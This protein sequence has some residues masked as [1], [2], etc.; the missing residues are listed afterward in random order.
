MTSTNSPPIRLIDFKDFKSLKKMPR[1]PEEKDICVKIDAI[2][3]DNSLIIYISHVWLRGKEEDEGFK[4][5]PHP[6]NTDHDHFELC[7]A[8]IK[9]LKK[10]FAPDMKKCYLWLDFG[11]LNQDKDPFTA[12]GAQ[13]ETI[14]GLSDCLFTPLIGK[15]K[16]SKNGQKSKSPIT[17]YYEQFNLRSWNGDEGYLNHAWCRT[18]ILLC[19]SSSQLS[20]GDSSRVDKFRLQFRELTLT[21]SRPHV[22]FSTRELEDESDPMM[23][24]LQGRW[25]SIYS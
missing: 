19:S 8:G 12:H 21:G 11:C 18:E 7:V 16:T 6:D 4:K 20:V 13:L 9:A 2:D 24:K 22:L 10:S 5:R 3:R 17:D 1:Y 25:S 23:A 15:S 14:I